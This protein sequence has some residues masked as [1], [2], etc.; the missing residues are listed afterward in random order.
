MDGRSDLWRITIEPDS[1]AEARHAVEH[2]LGQRRQLV[3]RQRQAPE[4]RKGAEYVYR[5]SHPGQATGT[6]L[7][8]EVEQSRRGYTTRVIIGPDGTDYWGSS[9]PFRIRAL[10]TT[11]KTEWSPYTEYT[12]GNN[13]TPANISSAELRQTYDTR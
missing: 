2:S 1:D 9:W 8:Y 3:V 12:C 13:C 6:L 11:G 5:W 4:P 7:G 10:Y